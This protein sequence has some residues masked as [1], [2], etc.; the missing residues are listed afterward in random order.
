MTVLVFDTETT[1]L[2]SRDNNL[3]AISWQLIRLKRSRGAWSHVVLEKKS[4]YFDWPD[5]DRVTY[6]AI[7]VNGLTKGRLA[8][9]GTVPRTEGLSLFMDA[10]ERAGAVVAHNLYFDK[11]FVREEIKR[12]GLGPVGFPDGFCTMR[13]MMEWCAIPQYED[14]YSLPSLG[15]LAYCLKVDSTGGKVEVTKRCFMKILETGEVLPYI[16]EP[17]KA[18]R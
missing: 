2:E 3:L 7:N 6:E 5:E 12:E 8:E 13:E 18:S 17:K 1:G 14:G 10:L 15:M 11:G 4:V 9:L 16:P